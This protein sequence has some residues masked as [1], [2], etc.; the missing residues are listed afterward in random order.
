ME[1]ANV[2][3]EEEAAKLREAKEGGRSQGAARNTRGEGGWK[4]EIKRQGT[5]G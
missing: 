5:G 4:R 3:G 2:S 1:A